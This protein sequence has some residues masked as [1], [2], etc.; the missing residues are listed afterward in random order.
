MSL[1]V[2]LRLI[3]FNLRV[4]LCTRNLRIPQVCSVETSPDCRDHQVL[5]AVLVHD[6]CLLPTYPCT[7]H[8]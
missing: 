6:D 2:I 8:L 3:V 4:I 7:S 1:Y 5:Q